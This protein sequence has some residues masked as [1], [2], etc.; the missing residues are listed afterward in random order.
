MIYTIINLVITFNLLHL[1]VPMQLVGR[2]EDEGLRMGMEVE[3]L[4]KKMVV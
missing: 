4:G 3:D 2:V 1:E